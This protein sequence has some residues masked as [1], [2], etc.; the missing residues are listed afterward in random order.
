MHLR[1]IVTTLAGVLLLLGACSGADGDRP[2]P[3][4]AVAP[5]SVTCAQTVCGEQVKRCEDSNDRLRSDCYDSCVYNSDPVGCASV[6]RS[7]GSSSCVCST[8][9]DSCAEY[10]VEFSPPSLN[11]KIYDE[12]LAFLGLCFPDSE[13]PQES[14]AYAGRSYRHEYL[15]FLTCV[16]ERGCTAVDSC[17]PLFKLG[18]LGDTICA[19]QAACGND[20]LTGVE[21]RTIGHYLNLEEGYLRP[22]LVA[23]LRRC[24]QEPD[25]K[26]ATACWEALK[27]AVGIG[28]YPAQPEQSK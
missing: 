8:K 9:D 11:G 7:I 14:A 22:A 24:S 3:A 28:D 15:D 6:C 19:R 10:G 26:V 2:D 5:Y 4:D 25:C 23:E 16:R 13:A 21:A 1:G 17:D 27:P 18:D 20:C 12:E